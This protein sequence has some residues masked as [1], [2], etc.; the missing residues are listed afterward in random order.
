MGAGRERLRHLEDAAHEQVDAEQH[1]EDRDGLRGPDQ[2]G[3][4]EQ[5]GQHTDGEQQPPAPP[6]SGKRVALVRGHFGRGHA[7]SFVGH[8]LVAVRRCS[9]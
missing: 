2:A 4:A 3:E 9:A 5:Q 6:D 7:F 1:G 8:G